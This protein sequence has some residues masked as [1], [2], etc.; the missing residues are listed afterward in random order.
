MN[1]TWYELEAGEAMVGVVI[2][3]VVVTL[4]VLAMT[5]L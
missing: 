4:A 1:Q 2:A 3:V 5:F